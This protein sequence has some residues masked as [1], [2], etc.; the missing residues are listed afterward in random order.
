MFWSLRACASSPTCCSLPWGGQ[1]ELSPGGSRK[2][3]A[4]WDCGSE[5]STA[6][7]VSQQSWLLPAQGREILTEIGWEF[8]SFK[9]PNLII[10]NLLAAHRQLRSVIFCWE[11]L[12]YF[13]AEFLH[14]HFPALLLG[15][16]FQGQKALYSQDS[17]PCR[18][19]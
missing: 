11:M 13:K 5:A 8:F 4:M 1:T 14:T 3:M 6:A 18:Y 7:R 19:S 9:I 17:S 16:I 10:H 2:G 15:P 12:S